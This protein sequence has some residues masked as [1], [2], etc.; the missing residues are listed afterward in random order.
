M[1]VIDK[2]ARLGRRLFLR[3]AATAVPATALATAGIDAPAEAANAEVLKPDTMATLVRMSRDLYPHDRLATRYYIKAC[4]TFD[5]KAAADATVR[6]ML[7]EGAATLDAA[8]QARFRRAYRD[9]PQETDRVALLEGIRETPFLNKV[10]SDLVVSLYNQPDL[11][12]RFG[13]EGSSFEHGGYINRGF[14]D[15]DW[16]PQS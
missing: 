3:S 12:Q 16:L 14:D 2:R 9:V 13:Y 1:R 15:I 7:D 11:W 5:E 6:A 4:A 10:R 8:S